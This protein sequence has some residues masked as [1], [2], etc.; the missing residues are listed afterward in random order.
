MVDVSIIIL[1]YNHFDMLNNTIDSIFCKVKNTNYETIIIEGD[2]LQFLPIDPRLRI[3]KNDKNIGWPSA[4][5]QGLSYAYGNYICIIDNDVLL[6]DDVISYFMKISIAN[7][8]N[9][10]LAP[11][12]FNGDNT[13]Q[14]SV[15]DFPSITNQLGV[16]FFL[17][18]LF[19]SS[20]IFNPWHTVH[21]KAEE[22]QPVDMV[23]GAC[24]F[25]H[26]SVAIRRNG[27]ESRYFFYFSD[28]DFCLTHKRNMGKVLYCPL[29]KV[30]H[31]GS[32]ASKGTKYSGNHH[33]A[34]D[35]V[36]FYKK[37]YKESKAFMLIAINIMASVNRFLVWG[38]AGVVTFRKSM[39]I[40]AY[41]LLIRGMIV[42]RN[43][44][45]TDR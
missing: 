12:V 27:F 31:Y 5:N 36:T 38:T 15:E 42:A 9:V 29:V 19:P 33:F 28:T 4:I 30:I 20:G 32:V 35:T 43:I 8:D 7:N 16:A 39:L 10:I 34:K 22:I 1:S 25:F 6:L 40:K 23:I 3:Y 14:T 17:N 45:I 13:I 18:V 11:K 41:Y 44:I 24:M 2:V 37:N 26:K 21:H